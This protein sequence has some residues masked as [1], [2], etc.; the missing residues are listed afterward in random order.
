MKKVRGGGGAFTREPIDHVTDLVFLQGEQLVTGR[1]AAEQF[2]SAVE[3][4][5]TQPG[6]EILKIRKYKKKK[7]KKRPES[8]YIDFLGRCIGG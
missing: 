3:S 7:K 1:A 5:E 4:G 6:E 8:S 2:P